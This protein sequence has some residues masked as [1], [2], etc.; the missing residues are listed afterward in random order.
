MADNVTANP[1]SGGATFAADDVGGVLFPYAKLDIG[2]DG[3]SSPVSASNPLPVSGP[4]TD[5][6]LRADAVPVAGAGE[7]IETLEAI[8]MAM[9][10]L[11]RAAGL[12]TVDT[13]GR[14]R[15]LLDAITASLTLAT[16]TTVTTVTTVSTV[17]NQ[18]Q[19]GGF[20]AQDQIPALMHLQADN[21]RRN[22]SV[23]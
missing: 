19:M 11:T 13:S 16:I 18:A 20:A 5:T 17:T 7:L 3:A 12:L 6:Q 1:G 2:G 23:T 21:L 8:R 10:S 4:L 9:Q 14:V 22:I 15:M